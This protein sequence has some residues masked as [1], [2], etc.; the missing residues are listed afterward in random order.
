MSFFFLIWAKVLPRLTNTLRVQWRKIPMS[1]HPQKL[2]W[3]TKAVVCHWCCL[4][5]AVS[6]SWTWGESKCRRE[7][8]WMQ[9]AA[10]LHTSLYFHDFPHVEMFGFS[11]LLTCH[12]MPLNWCDCDKFGSKMEMTRAHTHTH[13]RA[14]THTW[15]SNGDVCGAIWNV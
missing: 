4:V 15:E 6:F 2:C 3:S 11:V 12:V 14:R 9:C 1:Q 7:T 8:V 13:E 10:P 5:T